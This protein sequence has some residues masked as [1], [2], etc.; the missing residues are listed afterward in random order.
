MR[1][2]SPPAADGLSEEVVLAISA[3]VAAYLGKGPHIRQIRLLGSQAGAAAGAPHHP[4]VTRTFRVC[5]KKGSDPLV[6]GGLTPFSHRLRGYSSVNA[7]ARRKARQGGRPCN[8]RSRWT[9]RYTRSRWR[10]MSRKRPDPPKSRLRGTPRRRPLLPARAP[11]PVLDSR[12]GREQGVPQP[13]RRDGRQDPNPGRPSIKV[14]DVLMVL[15][16]MK[17]ETVITAP[18]AGKVM[19]DQRQGRR[20]RAGRT[21]PRRVRVTCRAAGLRCIAPGPPHSGRR[22]RRSPSATSRQTT[23]SRWRTSP[24]PGPAVPPRGHVRRISSADVRREERP[25]VHDETGPPAGHVERRR[26]AGRLFEQFGHL[27]MSSG[28]AQ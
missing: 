15:E 28:P 25:R 3:A 21:D 4:G 11:P 8:S 12:G 9:A 2:A 26:F 17:M 16:A 27:G 7:A 1:G 13:H 6:L 22:R 20:L 18:I 10:R 23:G 19:Q 5:A 24:P 14:S